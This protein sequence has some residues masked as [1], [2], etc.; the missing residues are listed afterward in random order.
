MRGKQLQTNAFQLASELGNHEDSS[1]SEPCDTSMEEPDEAVTKLDKNIIVEQ[2]LKQQLLA[3]AY[4]SISEQILEEV[5]E[6]SDQDSSSDSAQNIICMF[7]KAIKFDQEAILYWCC[8]IEKYDKRIDYLISSGVNEK[9][10]HLRYIKKSN[11]F[12]LI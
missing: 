6:V 4:V 8:F 2:E 11:S 5:P 3:P 1:W 7:R 12:Y 10:W 9:L